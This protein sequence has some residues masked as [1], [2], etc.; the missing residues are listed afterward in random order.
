MTNDRNVL[1]YRVQVNDDDNRC[2]WT[3]TRRDAGI[4]RRRQ[5]GCEKTVVE[6]DEKKTGEEKEK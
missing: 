2:G 6:N 3:R 4:S 1:T 5:N